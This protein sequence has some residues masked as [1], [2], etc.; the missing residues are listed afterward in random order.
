[1]QQAWDAAIVR[2]QT[3]E[4]RRKGARTAVARALFGL[5]GRRDG[6][7]VRCGRACSGRG[8][9]TKGHS[10]GQARCTRSTAVGAGATQQ[11]PLFRAAHSCG[12]VCDRLDRRSSGQI[13]VRRRR[14]HGMQACGLAGGGREV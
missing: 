11:R 10:S 5:R 4:G 12:P 7:Q 6:E 2:G 8:T 9:L 3:A 13:T 14:W 1:M